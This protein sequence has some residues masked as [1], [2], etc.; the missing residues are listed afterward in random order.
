MNEKNH[1]ASYKVPNASS[2]YWDEHVRPGGK[3]FDNP[4]V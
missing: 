3:K 2:I 4:Q 1:G